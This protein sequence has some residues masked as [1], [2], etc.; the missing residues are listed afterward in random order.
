M[1]SF[2]ISSLI[3]EASK[4]QSI[5]PTH[6]LLDEW[7]TSGRKRATIYDLLQC[8]IHT[9][10][11]R[12][13]E[14]VAIE[15]LN[16]PAPQRPANGPGARWISKFIFDD[17]SD[18]VSLMNDHAEP[19]VISS[20]EVELNMCA[21][22]ISSKISCSKDNSDSDDSDYTESDPLSSNL[23]SQPNDWQKSNDESK[24]FTSN[25]ESKQFN[26]NDPHVMPI[27]AMF[28]GWKLNNVKKS[29]RFSR[30]SLNF[31][32][33]CD[34]D[35]SNYIPN[36]SSSLHQLDVTINSKNQ[37]KECNSDNS[38]FIPKFTSLNGSMHEDS[39]GHLYN[40]IKANDESS[41]CNSDNSHFIPNFTL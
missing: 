4:Q 40:S 35:D 27:S 26:S 14:Y 10:L 15:L 6:M 28:D 7:G 22:D 31:N 25:D 21:L 18:S 41:K 11:F 1:F 16:E 8:L 3:I 19:E 2:F 17:I 9:K 38:N 13:A 30:L 5:S 23:N 34:S 29:E 36:F 24:K 33:E 12:A 20:N 39:N 32:D 37:S